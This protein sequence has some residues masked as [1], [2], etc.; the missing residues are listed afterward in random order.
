[1]SRVQTLKKWKPTLKKR[2]WTLKNTERK[3]PIFYGN[4]L[5]KN[6][7]KEANTEKKETN[8]EKKEANTEKK[9][10]N[11][12]KKETNTEKKETNTEKHWIIIY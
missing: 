2:S 5:P 11:T 9:E 6:E 1:M 10:T 7:K 8:T 3:F 12:E 4:L